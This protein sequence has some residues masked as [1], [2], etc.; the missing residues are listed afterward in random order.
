MKAIDALLPVALLGTERAGDVPAAVRKISGIADE[1]LS[2]LAADGTVA[3]HTLVLRAAAVLGQCQRVGFVVAP[4]SAPPGSIVTEGPPALDDPEWLVRIERV[5][6]LGPAALQHDLLRTVAARGYRLHAKLLP[7]ALDLASSEPSLRDAVGAVLGGRGRWL[8]GQR[9]RWTDALAPPASPTED[10]WSHG[11]TAARVAFLRHERAT[12]PDAAR[13]RLTGELAQLG[14]DE[15]TELVGCLAVGLGPADEVLLQALLGDRAVEVRR[16]AARLLVRLP[17]SA[18]STAIGAALAALLGKDKRG[19]WTIDAPDTEPP[20]VKALGL[21]PRPKTDEL[22]E[23]AFWLFQLVRNAPLATWT[24]NTGMSPAEIVAWAAKS[25]WSAAL[26]RGIRDALLAAPDLEWTRALLGKWV[27][28]ALGPS[29]EDVQALL[30][31]PERERVWKAHLERERAPGLLHVVDEIASVA[32]PEDRLGPDLAALLARLLSVSLGTNDSAFDGDDADSL[33]VAC[34]ALPD[35]ALSP[36]KTIR[37]DDRLMPRFD[38]T[39]DRVEQL[40]DVRL[41]IA[42]LASAPPAAVIPRIP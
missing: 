8:A 41:R 36:L 24:T 34:A 39:V 12:A 6:E 10:D 19:A 3:P 35:V 1:V 33:L 22:G 13:E 31:W 26:L 23:R 11:R 17:A 32:G 9:K 38:E 2:A 30:P 29:D 37:R 14:A 28:K 40:V 20:G 42:S 18:R 4:P 15:R 27:V 25:D 7:A 16:R 5:F 21:E